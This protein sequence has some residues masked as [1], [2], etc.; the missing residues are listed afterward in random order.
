MPSLNP[1]RVWIG[2]PEVGVT[3]GFLGVF[4]GRCRA[5]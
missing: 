1:D 5:S 3:L 4:A 2:A